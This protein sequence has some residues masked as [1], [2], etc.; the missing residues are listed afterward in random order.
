M[1][2][3]SLSGSRAN[4][5]PLLPCLFVR[6]RTCTFW[7]IAFRLDG[8][9]GKKTPAKLRVSRNPDPGSWFQ[10][11]GSWLQDPGSWLQDPG[12]W[13]QDP[14]SWLQDA[15][16]WLQDPGSWL[17][18]PWSWILDLQKVNHPWYG[19]MLPEKQS[20]CSFSN[21]PLKAVNDNRVARDLSK[22]L[23]V[24]QDPIGGF[25]KLQRIF[26]LQRFLCEGIWVW[27]CLTLP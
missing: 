1:V 20:S 8:S 14:G 25:G 12:S 26:E 2:E 7:K 24:A 17:Q 4:R 10:D 27:S 19:E 5:N 21:R 23:W 13:L 11:P 16:S 22:G 3:V 18:D 6:G 15:G 9:T